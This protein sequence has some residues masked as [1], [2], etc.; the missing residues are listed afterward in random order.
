M[1]A[2]KLKDWQRTVEDTAAKQDTRLAGLTTAEAQRR[3]EKYGHNE[4]ATKGKTTLLQKFLAQFKD[5]MII[6]LLV[7]ALISVFV[8]EGVDALIILLVVVLNAI[9]GVF[10]ESKAEEAIDALK[11]LAAPQ[12]KVERDGQM[13]QIQSTE[14]VPGDVVILEAGDVV[15]ADLRLVESASMQIEESALTGESVPVNK[16]TAAL[17]DEQLPLGDRTNLAF[18][19]SNVTFG[20]G[21]GIVIHTGMATEVG[22][23]ARLIND[24]DETIT[25]LQRNLTKLSKTLTWLI[26]AIAVVVFA[27]GMLRGQESLI[28]MLLTAISLAVAAIPEG[29]PAIVTITLALGT[30]RMV[31]RHAIIR[32]LPAVETLGSTQIIASDKTGTLTQ[33]KMTVEKLFVDNQLMDAAAVTPDFQSKLFDLMILNN[34]TKKLTRSWWGILPKRP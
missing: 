7:A 22:K 3:L 12:A 11:S 32:K 8:G 27:V 2:S 1:K 31:K 9:F 18:M 34:D 5:L 26:L 28:D 33:N 25:P 6:V 29:L 23:I 30:Q 21:K 16:Q 17:D 20:R 10:Q 4:L 19:N 14:L 15:P 13:Q 24:A